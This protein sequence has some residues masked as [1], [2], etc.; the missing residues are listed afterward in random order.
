MRRKTFRTYCP[1]CG[2]KIEYQ[3]LP[4]FKGEFRCPHCG[5]EFKIPTLLDFTTPRIIKVLQRSD[6]IVPVESV[7]FWGANQR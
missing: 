1:G 6:R 7:H 4:G 2:Y 5:H 3:P